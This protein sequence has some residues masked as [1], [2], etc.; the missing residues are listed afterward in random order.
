GTSAVRWTGE[1]A[2]HSTEQGADEFRRTES[3]H[4]AA[5]ISI[6]MPATL[7]T[8]RA[9]KPQSTKRPARYAP[10]AMVNMQRPRSAANTRP[11]NLSSLC[12]CNSVVENTHTIEPPECASITHKQACQRC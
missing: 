8:L 12:R 10:A 11:R 2:R 3:P 9:A 6:N 7:A 5:G 1:D 4:S